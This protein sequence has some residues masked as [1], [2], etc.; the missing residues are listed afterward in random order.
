[1]G[2][3]GSVASWKLLVTPTTKKTAERVAAQNGATQRRLE[4]RP[5]KGRPTK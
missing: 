1:M 2:K 4:R 5:L 3:I